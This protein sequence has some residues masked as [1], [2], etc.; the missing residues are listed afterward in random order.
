MNGIAR[1]RRPPRCRGREVS[2]P[3]AGRIGHQFR[4]WSQA[5][6]CSPWTSRRT[7]SACACGFSTAAATQALG[8]AR[9]TSKV[10]S[11]APRR[12]R[13]AARPTSSRP[14]GAG[15]ACWEGRRRTCRPDQH[16][17]GH[18]G[19]QAAV[20]GQQCVRSTRLS[21]SARSSAL[22]QVS[23]M[24]L[25]A[26]CRAVCSSTGSGRCRTSAPASCRSAPAAR[27][28]AAPGGAW[29]RAPRSSRAPARRRP[30]RSRPSRRARSPRCGRRPWCTR[31]TRARRRTPRP[32]G[33]WPGCRGT[34]TARPAH[35]CRSGGMPSPPHRA[36]DQRHR[37]AALVV[38][39]LHLLRVEHP[40]RVVEREPLGLR[41]PVPRSS[42]RVHWYAAQRAHSHGVIS[43]ASS[44]SW[45]S[46]TRWPLR[47]HRDRPVV[48]QRRR[49]VTGAFGCQGAVDEGVVLTGHQV[50]DPL[51]PAESAAAA[52]AVEEVGMAPVDV[53][54]RP[55][56]KVLRRICGQP[57]SFSTDCSSPS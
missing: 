57:T 7:A 3:G 24:S 33:R 40:E 42:A 54:R 39:R 9:S 29:R 1:P 22:I 18:V 6:W 11:T 43:S 26:T 46:R 12:M 56:R 8:G 48:L 25:S 4:P 19:D 28:P 55:G 45:V 44:A 38:R 52:G 21:A 20:L 10:P 37:V 32:G 50:A 34:G 13:Y 17:V 2:E 49:R 35:S 36:H 47:E 27:S 23:A 31:P 15:P 16:Q 53:R 14:P 30:G 41:R 51:A 5:P